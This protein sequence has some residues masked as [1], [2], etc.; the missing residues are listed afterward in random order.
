MHISESENKNRG[1]DDNH[2]MQEAET[3]D[4]SE[5]MGPKVLA[6][7]VRAAITELINNKADG[8]DNISAEMLKTWNRSHERINKAM[9][10]LYHRSMARGFPAILHDTDKKESRCNSMR[11]PPHHKLPHTYLKDHDDNT[12]KECKQRRRQSMEYE[13]TISDLERRGNK[14]C[15]RNI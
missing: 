13:T 3:R 4:R 11:R 7:E 6:E 8:I 9:P 12:N 15:D 2:D 14:R 1:L 5:D 10:R